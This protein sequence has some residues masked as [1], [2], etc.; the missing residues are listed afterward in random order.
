MACGHWAGAGGGVMGGTKSCYLYSDAGRRHIILVVF[1]QG[2]KL[3]QVSTGSPSTGSAGGG[4]LWVEG[5]NKY[6]HL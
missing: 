5:G 1:S 4:V 6:K 2:L 3:M